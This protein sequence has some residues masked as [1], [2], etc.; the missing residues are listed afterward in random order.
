[1]LDFFM[2][3]RGELNEELER[4]GC[5]ELLKK[6]ILKGINRFNFVTDRNSGIR[7]NDCGE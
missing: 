3:Q 7:K 4:A 1:M 5:R 6:L 2:T